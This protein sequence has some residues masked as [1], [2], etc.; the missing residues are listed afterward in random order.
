[1]TRPLNMTRGQDPGQPPETY[2]LEANSLTATTDAAPSQRAEPGVIL[3]QG[4]G[5]RRKARMPRVP[6][7][8]ASVYA[9]C[10]RRHLWAFAYVCPWCKLG[11]LGRAKTEAEVS[12]PRRSRCGRLVVIRVARVYRGR[13]NSG[14]AA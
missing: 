13:A 14:A 3:R 6:V 11:H 12:G 10:E 4:G 1:V 7:V 2:P 5:K 8:Y 9:P